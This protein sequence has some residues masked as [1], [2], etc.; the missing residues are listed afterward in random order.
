[1]PQTFWWR[2]RRCPSQREKTHYEAEYPEHGH[3]PRHPSLTHPSAL[4]NQRL[5]LG[6][7][8]DR[9]TTMSGESKRSEVKRPQSGSEPQT[10]DGAYD[11]LDNP[12]AEN[13]AENS[14]SAPRGNGPI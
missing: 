6:R 9:R 8:N 1:M 3:V 12:H 2:R 7:T 4:Q 10:S 11:L 5:S 14:L 13:P